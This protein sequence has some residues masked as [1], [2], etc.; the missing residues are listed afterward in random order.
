MNGVFMDEPD[1]RTR[2]V[3]QHSHY[4]STLMV[5]GNLPG[6]Y[7]YSVGNRATRRMIVDSF[8]IEGSWCTQTHAAT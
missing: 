3:N 2:R 5:T 4:C 7:Q 8:N 1:D 6:V